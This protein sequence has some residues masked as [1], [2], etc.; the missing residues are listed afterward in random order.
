M[1]PIGNYSMQTVV[2]LLPNI[3]TLP[4]ILA[5]ILKHFD[6]DFFLKPCA[7]KSDIQDSKK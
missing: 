4:N 2:L 6:I 1:V 7:L 3:Q 5:Y